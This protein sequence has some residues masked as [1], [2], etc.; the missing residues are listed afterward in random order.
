MVVFGASVRMVEGG[1]R[2]VRDQGLLCFVMPFDFGLQ[3]L[4]LYIDRP[5]SV[6]PQ[7]SYTI[8]YPVYVS[9]EMYVGVEASSE[10]G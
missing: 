3:V 1:G 6:W 2:F 4:V 9:M 7:P 5:V 8:K 10:T